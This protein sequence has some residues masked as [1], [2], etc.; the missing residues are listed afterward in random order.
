MNW[1]KINWNL[2]T[3][4]IRSEEVTEIIGRVP[5]WV[6]RRGITFIGFI[7]VGILIGAYFFKYPDIIISRITISSGNPPVKLVARSS[8]P[9]QQIFVGNN[10]EVQSGQTLCVLFNA[11]NYQD[12][13]KIAPLVRQLD[14]AVDLYTALQTIK[15]PPGLELGE[16]QSTYTELCVAVQ[17]YLFFATH[18]TYRATIGSLTKQLVYT[19]QL[20]QELSNKERMLQEQLILEHNRFA[21]DS[22]LV[23]DKVISPMEYNESKRKMLD[24][25]MTTGSNKSS[26]VQNNLLQ[27]GYQKDIAQLTLQ[28]QSDE[29]SLQQ[30]IKDAI[31][32]FNGQYAQWEEDYVIKSPTPG[33][34]TF[35]KYWKENQSVSAGEGIMMITPPVQEYIARGTIGIDHAGK[36]RTGQSVVI[37]LPAYPFEEYG[38]LK[39]QII[40]RSSVAMDADFALEIKLDNGLTTNTGKSIPQQPELEATGEILTENKSVL[41]RLFERVTGKLH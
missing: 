24:Q 34:V 2:A 32:R 1:S 36:I 11:A 16:L 21:A 5:P 6:T 23:K 10:E 33:K 18:N 37:K 29:N 4:I 26:M 20:Q 31:R 7:L 17:D 38:A 12:L 8:L 19:G 35:F 3:E 40:S 14:T 9:I 25:Q 41:E 28:K 15:I 22:S 13:Q 39:G 30:K 27:I